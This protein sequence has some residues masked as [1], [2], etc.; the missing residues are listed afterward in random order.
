MYWEELNQIASG[1]CSSY[2]R[3][4][5]DVV[6]G[7]RTRKHTEIQ[8][9]RVARPDF[10][11]QDMPACR[12]VASADA[13]TSKEAHFYQWRLF[14]CTSRSE[15]ERCGQV[16]TAQDWQVLLQ[17]IVEILHER[18]LINFRRHVIAPATGCKNKGK[19]TTGAQNLIWR[20]EQGRVWFVSWMVARTEDCTPAEYEM[21]EDKRGQACALWAKAGTGCK[22]RCT[23]MA[24][25]SM[26][27]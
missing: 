27:R 15:Q 1:R 7:S 6:L 12:L 22:W 19:G 3:C 26:T 2:R 13:L 25:L 18:E 20:T 5:H 9:R 24:A 11:Q 21:R 23:R 14:I 8:L 17:E 10:D 4:A 16:L